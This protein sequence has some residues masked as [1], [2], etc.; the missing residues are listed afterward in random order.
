MR[1]ARWVVRRGNPTKEEVLCRELGVRPK[2]ARLLVGRGHDTPEKA[3][4]F[5]EAK[6][7][8]QLR[9]PMLFRDMERAADRVVRA[10]TSGERIGVFGDYDVDGIAG[11]AILVG[12]LR[13]L[14]HDPALY[15]PHRLREGY[16]LSERGLRALAAEGVRLVVTVDCGGASHREIAFA[17]EA[18]M[19]VIVCD[20]HQV[21]ETR[22]PALAVLNPVEPDAGF[23]FSGLCG[24]GV[25]FYL[26]LGVRMRLRELGWSPLPDLR[27]FL[28]LVTL[29]TVA[30]IVPMVEENRVL[31]RYGLREIEKSLRP[32][33]AALKDV[34]GVSSV[35]TGV[36]GFR[37]APRLNA[38]GRLADATRGV[39]LLVTPDA[40]RARELAR[41]LDE[42]NRAR[43][44]I[45]DE[46]LTEALAMLEARDP[47]ERR[48]IVLGSPDWHPGVV[49]I[50]ASRLVDRFYRPT[51]LVGIDAARGLGRGSCRSIPAVDVYAALRKCASL[52]EG[53]GGHKMAAGLSIRPEKLEEF[54]ERF[55]KAVREATSP[56]DFVPRTLVDDELRAEEVASALVEDLEQLEP[57]GPGNPEPV[58]LLRGAEVVSRRVVG[59]NH[60][61]LFLRQGEHA[62]SAIGF[63][64]AELGE[65]ESGSTVDVL[66]VPER[67]DWS[68]GVRFRLKAVRPVAG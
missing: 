17:A 14:G 3:S 36:V 16:G 42:E 18:G 38:G 26:A 40:E 4:A 46:I 9:S 11:S 63:G 65:L 55:E 50:V 7:S 21:S 41:A 49:G 61:R 64:M 29:G 58:F 10:L 33:L 56:E 48:T 66:G 25:A 45:E 39:E 13:A 53:F 27:R 2:L 54:G 6:L 28:D 23:P 37:L 31:V 12:F 60:L 20:H 35:N 47:R 43:Q 32:G 67:D 1:A 19:D 22:L 52:L 57:F 68:G 30:D 59:S 24:A 44:R 51:V 34:S 5:L 15:I 8:T 62:L